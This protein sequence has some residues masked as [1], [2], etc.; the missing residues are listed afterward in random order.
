MIGAV[1][2]GGRNTRFP[3]LKGFIEAEGATLIERN[4]ELLRS[5][6][7]EVVISANE[8]QHYFRFG[9]PVIGDTVEPGGPLAGI[10]SVLRCTGAEAVLAVACDM[11][12]VQP[13][14][15]RY[16][17]SNNKSRVVVAGFEGRPQPLPGLYAASALGIM[18]EVLERGSRSIRELVE[19][20]G[21]VCLD[22]GEVRKIDPGGKS[23]VNINTVEDLS[24][25][26]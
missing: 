26:M 13:E 11:P 6:V 16:I 5:A 2:S 12:F 25:V 18:A 4:I 9:V 22:E 24:K 1:L 7:G 15:L 3:Y 10:Y 23:F 19:K 8:P 21:A 14:L 17:T 20:A